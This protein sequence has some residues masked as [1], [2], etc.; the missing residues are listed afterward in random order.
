MNKYLKVVIEVLISFVMRGGAMVTS[1][2]LFHGGTPYEGKLSCTV[3]TGGKEGDHFKI[4]P[5]SIIA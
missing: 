3:W 1:R 4:L 2:D 5:I